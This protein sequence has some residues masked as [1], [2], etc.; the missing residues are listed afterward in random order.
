MVGV[1]GPTEYKDV[2]RKFVHHTRAPLDLVIPDHSKCA[3]VLGARQG[4]A[5]GGANA[6]SLTASCAR[7]LLDRVGRDEETEPQVEQRN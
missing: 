4:Q 5:F 3:A 2:A 1:S 6:P 7:R